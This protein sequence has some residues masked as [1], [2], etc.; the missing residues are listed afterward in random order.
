MIQEEFRTDIGLFYVSKRG[1]RTT[2]DGNN[3]SK[4]SKYAVI[5]KGINSHSAINVN[6]FC[7]YCAETRERYGAE[8]NRI[9]TPW[10]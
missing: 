7:K 5:M 6:R 4:I 3:L 1:F 8:K 2:T 10:S 9:S